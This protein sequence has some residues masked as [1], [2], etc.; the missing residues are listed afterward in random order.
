MIENVYSIVVA[1]IAAAGIYMVPRYSSPLR[2]V[3]GLELLAG[4]AAAALVFWGGT[5]GLYLYMVG[6]DTAMMALAAAVVMHV[7]RRLRL[8][9]VDEAD[10]LK[11]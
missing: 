11:G 2:I 4:A 3:I 10:R 9:N 8:K 5:L 1:A 6:V 7:T